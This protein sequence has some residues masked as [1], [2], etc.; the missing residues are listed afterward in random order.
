MRE[1][2]S[3]Y[4]RTVM[5]RQAFLLAAGLVSMLALPIGFSVVLLVAVGALVGG[6]WW[7]AVQLAEPVARVDVRRLAVAVGGRWGLGVGGIYLGVGCQPGQLDLP[8][9]VLLVVSV[10]IGAMGG[11][12]AAGLTLCGVD[13]GRA[14]RHD[15]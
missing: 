14:I 12:A 3:P 5:G 13:A 7:W 10:A 4:V 8:M 2:G 6:A 1:G 15:G 11:V 9:Q